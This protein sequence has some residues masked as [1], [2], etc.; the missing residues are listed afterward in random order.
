VTILDLSGAQ[1]DLRIR[2][3]DN[4]AWTVNT[5]SDLSGWVWRGQIRATPADDVLGEFTITTTTSSAACQIP[6][7]VTRI[8]PRSSVYDVQVSQGSDVHTLLTG[9]ITTLPDVT[10]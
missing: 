7:D 2:A 6:A 9:K 5:T 3:G 1:L 8:L 10:R 4:P